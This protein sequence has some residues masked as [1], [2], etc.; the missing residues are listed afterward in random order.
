MIGIDYTGP[1]LYKRNKIDC[2]AYILLYAGSLTRAIHPELLPYQ[3]AE[4]LL[5]SLKRFIA[6]RGRPEEIYS[7]TDRTF[8]AGTKWLKKVMRDEA[9]QNML[10]RREIK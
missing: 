6:R 2:K 8:A 3:T 1:I 9:I 4:D 7:D 5:L 10:A